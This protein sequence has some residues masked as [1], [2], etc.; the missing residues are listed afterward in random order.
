MKKVVW[1]L[2]LIL[3]KAHEKEHSNISQLTAAQEF[4]D[5]V[6]FMKAQLHVARNVKKHC[7]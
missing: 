1:E 3:K 4:G 2:S 5:L 7:Y 6:S